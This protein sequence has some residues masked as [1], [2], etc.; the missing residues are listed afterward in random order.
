MRQELNEFLISSDQAFYDQESVGS[1]EDHAKWMHEIEF[2]FNGYANKLNSLLEGKSG[3]VVE[4]GAGS[5]GLSSCLSRLSNVRHITSLDIS[6]LRMQK[7]IDLS[8]LALGGDKRKIHPIASDFNG[9]LPFEDGELDVVVFDAA[10]HH[11]RS[12]WTTLAECYRVLKAGGILVAQRE[13]FLNPLRAKK[14][15]AELLKSP[16]AAAKVSE[17]MYLKEQYIYYL[18]MAGFNVEFQPRS[19][20]KLKSIL[21]ILNGIAFCDGI[22]WCRK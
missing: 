7:M 9:P 14:Q 11:T 3:Y 16:E 17:N 10:L 18:R 5:C 12:M 8:E 13:L 22:F 4:L 19:P 1:F 2:Y 20:S 15:I 21:H 6:M